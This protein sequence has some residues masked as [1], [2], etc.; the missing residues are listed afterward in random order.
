M[1]TDKLKLIET[2]LNI[3]L[4]L[5]YK[6]IM[7]NYPFENGNEFVKGELQNDP[8]MLIDINLGLRKNGFKGKPWPENFY[9]ISSTTGGGFNFIN[10]EEQNENIYLASSDKKSF[11]P[12]KLENYIHCNSFQEYIEHL[13]VLQRI[14]D[15]P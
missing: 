12:K 14:H 13:K 3:N 9:V 15:N 8:K 6:Q 7:L 5:G 2:E 11:N 1:T 10:L 4:P